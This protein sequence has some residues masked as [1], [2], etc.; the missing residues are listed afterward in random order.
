MEITRRYKSKYG[1]HTPKQTK[2]IINIFAKKCAIPFTDSSWHNDAVDSLYYEVSCDEEL[3]YLQVYIP[4]SKE[5]DVDQEKFNTFTVANSDSVTLFESED[6]KK[7]IKFLNKKSIKINIAK[8]LKNAKVIKKVK[9][10]AKKKAKAEKIANL[11]KEAL[12]MM[13]AMDEKYGRSTMLSLDDYVTD[14]GHVLSY[15]EKN[16]MLDLLNKF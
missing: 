15:D 4:N 12:E 3:E 14:F 16:D 5:D 7:V 6:I 1:F 10:N 13:S 9:K 11:H 8:N 2:K